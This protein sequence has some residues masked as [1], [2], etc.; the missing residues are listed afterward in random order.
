M[1]H[2]TITLFI[3]VLSA[4]V[5]VGANITYIPLL[6]KAKQD[7]NSAIQTLKTIRFLDSRLANPAYIVA[8]VTGLVM[9]FTVPFSIT[10]PWILSA[11]ILYLLI[12]VLGIFVYAPAFRRQKHL[13]E[14]EGVQSAAYQAAARRGNMLIGLVTLFAVFIVFLMVVKPPL[15]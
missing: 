7:Q 9:V 14:N 6:G 4:I 5:A 1:T 3:H 8:L 2:F 13:A 12:F 15:W 11:L 10:T